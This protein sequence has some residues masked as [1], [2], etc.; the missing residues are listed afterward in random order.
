MLR[1]EIKGA[2]RTA[3]AEKDETAKSTVRLIMAA[4]K[5]RDIEARAKGNTDGIADA[6]I[7]GMLQSMIKQRR[8]SIEMYEKGGR[9]ELAQQEAAEI[10]V[11]QRFLPRQIEGAE[12]DQAIDS[13]IAEVG[14]A[15]IKDMGKV[16]AALRGAHAGQMDF[17][18]ASDRVKARLAG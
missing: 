5:D 16:M 14:A 8:E 18:R 17:G 2:L 15:S 11:I 7:L 12:M 13:A 3:M 6:D 1:D 10:D 9:C 4:L